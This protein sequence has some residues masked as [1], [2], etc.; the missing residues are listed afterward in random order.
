MNKKSYSKAFSLMEIII[1]MG[2]IV[3]FLTGA[4]TLISYGVSG[5]RLG[6]SKITAM[7]LAQEGLEI[8]RNIRDNNWL[9]NK[10]A[11]NDWRDGLN[12]GYYRAQYDKTN[13]IS[14]S[15]DKLSLDGNGF[16][17][18]QD[19]GSRA[20]S[21]ITPFKRDINIEYFPGDDTQIKV[22]SNVAWEEQGR[23]NTISV[24]TR[25]YNWLEPDE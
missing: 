17:Y 8:V 7:A 18:Y 12:S 10:R 14:A 24:E 25:L 20:N 5:I 16:Y 15:N 6:K 21:I 3:T 19:Q 11:S 22:T 4:I 23:T 13:L 1:V 9:S 2:V